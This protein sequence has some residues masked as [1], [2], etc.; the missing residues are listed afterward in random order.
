M[1]ENSIEYLN[2]NTLI[3]C[4]AIDGNAWHW[5]GITQNHYDGFVPVADIKGRLFNWQAE[6]RPLSIMAEGYD[7]A[8]ADSGRDRDLELIVHAI[9]THKALVRVDRNDDGTESINKVFGFV[10]D[11]H[12][13]HQYDEWLLE[14][15]KV[16]L[17]ETDDGMGVG[18]AGLLRV[19]AQAWVQ[20]RPSDTMTIGD[21]KY[22]PYL[23]ATTSHDGSIAT[24]YK[25]CCQ[26]VV[27]DNTLSVA[28]GENKAS[29]KVKHTVGSVL[30]IAKAREVLEMFQ[31]QVDE[32]SREVE[33]LM[34]TEMKKNQLADTIKR[35]YGAK[36]AEEL[37]VVVGA[38]GNDTKVTNTRAINNWDRRFDEIM[39]MWDD[40]RVADYAN[41]A[42]GGFMANNTWGQWG[43]AERDSN[44]RDTADVKLAQL[45]AQVGGSWEQH[46]RLWLASQAAVLEAV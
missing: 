11:I 16:L 19:G 22:L 30:E 9:D 14:N 39:A 17:D 45:T 5:D 33:Q 28:M 46:D 40:P 2:A 38:D 41:T 42:W 21:D 18:S 34:N 23:L 7:P 20:V 35:V 13:I 8:V 1:S 12:A 44:D 31:G 37:E 3:G 36:P 4:R 6:Y 10:T 29:F 43:V 32:F 15:V 25:W 27:C 24:T 26:R